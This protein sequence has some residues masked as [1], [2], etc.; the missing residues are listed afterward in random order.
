MSAWASGAWASGAWAGT[1]WASGNASSGS[2]WFE[3]AW[4]SGA[5][6]SSAWYV[7][8]STPPTPTP[9]EETRI[10][11]LAFRQRTGELFPLVLDAE[12]VPIAYQ[13]PGGAVTLRFLDRVTLGVAISEPSGETLIII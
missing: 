10:P 3:N 7:A 11:R 4:A 9:G 2:S 6:V 8:G 1:V 13:A 5:W 12:N